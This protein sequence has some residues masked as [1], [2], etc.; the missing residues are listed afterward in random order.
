MSPSQAIVASIHRYPV[1]SM[2][3]EELNSVAITTRGVAGDR[4]Y[5]LIDVETNKLVNA[6]HPQKWPE[7]FAYRACYTSPPVSPEHVPPV[8]IALPNGDVIESTSGDAEQTLSAALRKRV[9]LVRPDESNKGFEG[10]VPTVEGVSD[11]DFVFDK[12]S[13]PGTF[14]D[15]GL[16]HILTT[17]TID[18][19]RKTVP[20]SRIESRRFRPNLVIR[21]DGAEGFVENTW[22]GRTLRIG[23]V[24]LQVKQPTQRCVMTTLAQ[25]DLPK[26][27]SVLKAIYRHNAGTIGV[28]AEPVQIGTVRV[29]DAV[30]LN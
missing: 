14:F 25:G 24:V 4:A 18:A 20:H 3:G 8:Y 1:K 2:M 11:R 10:F 26:D 22:V 7:M 29:N 28:Y 19:L 17:S 12:I 16:I 15:I 23:Q 6:K 13:P 27:M 30:E 9:R 21:T 5:S